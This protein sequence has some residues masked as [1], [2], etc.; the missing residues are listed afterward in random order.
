MCIHTDLVMDELLV[1]VFVKSFCT[2]II[3][4]PVSVSLH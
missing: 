4:L 1:E 3:T 2:A